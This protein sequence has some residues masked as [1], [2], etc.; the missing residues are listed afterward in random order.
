MGD[1]LTA[2]LGG[3]GTGLLGGLFTSVIGYFQKKSQQKYELQKIAAESQA[4]IDEANANIALNRAQVEGQVDLAET[5]AFRSSIANDSKYIKEEM[6]V[7]L[8]KSDRFFLKLIGAGVIFLLGLVDFLKGLVRP[9]ITYYLIGVSTYLTM[10][11]YDIVQKVGPEM[12]DKTAMNLFNQT[13]LA[14]IYLTIT[15][16]SWWFGERGMKRGLEMFSKGGK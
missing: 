10:L 11:A 4:T 9:L 8:I 1:V 5:K 7:S 14:I 2:I 6:L 3:G 15:A 13:V 12:I 16:V